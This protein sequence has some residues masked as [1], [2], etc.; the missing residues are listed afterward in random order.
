MNRRRTLAAL[1]AVTTISSSFAAACGP[2]NRGTDPRDS[3]AA[4]TPV[5]ITAW[6]AARATT[7]LTGGHRPVREEHDRASGAGRGVGPVPDLDAGDV[8]EHGDRR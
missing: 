4:K 7:H 1:A 6:H 2:V 5:T 8:R 3:A